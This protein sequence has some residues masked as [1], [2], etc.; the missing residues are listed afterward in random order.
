M[1][2]RVTLDEAQAQLT[3]LIDAA[4]NGETVFIA[5]NDDQIVQLVP[6]GHRAGHPQFGRGKGL[7][8]MA[9]DFDELLADFDEYMR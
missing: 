1:V 5:T 4:V 6:V 3:E 2:H 8:V 9:D 7:M